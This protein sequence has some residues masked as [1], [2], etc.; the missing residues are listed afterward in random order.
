MKFHELKQKIMEIVH[1]K[2]NLLG[3]FEEIEKVDIEKLDSQET[4]IFYLIKVNGKKKCFFKADLANTSKLEYEKKVLENLPEDIGP[5]PYFLD[6]NKTTLP[7]DYMITS[8]L[9]GKTLQIFFEMH[10][11][12]FARKLAEL[13]KLKH[14]CYGS[15]GSRKKKLNIWNMFVEENEQYFNTTPSLM[16]DE[17]LEQL[18]GYFQKFLMEQQPIFDQITEF[19]L[20]HQNLSPQNILFDEH[21]AYLINWDKAQYG[22]NA[23]DI[24]TFYYD[25]IWF[26]KWRVKLD[27]ERKTIFIDNYLKAYWSDPSFKQR[28][29][30]WMIYDMFSSLV[31]CR[32][33]H[34]NYDAQDPNKTLN[35]KELQQQSEE[36]CN[37]LK[38]K[39]GI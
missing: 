6:T 35:K 2:Q 37:V 8:F 34:H 39:L 3:I 9:R 32:Y 21:E 38:K 29:E 20:L 5:Y 30:I 18:L 28:V 4:D 12:L 36:L 27:P 22:D 23:K 10:L 26:N 16:H 25:D 13:H 33:K 1:E 19:S 31:Q 7:F 17:Y 11:I 24:V 15:L 14:D